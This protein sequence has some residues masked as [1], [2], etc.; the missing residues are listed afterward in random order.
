MNQISV[1]SSQKYKSKFNYKFDEAEHDITD[2]IHCVERYGRQ[3]ALSNS[4]LCYIACSNFKNME[5]A[6]LVLDSI[7][8]EDQ[9]DW[10][11]V[12]SILLSQFGKTRQDWW[13]EFG[14]RKRKST[15]S[16]H[17]LLAALTLLHKKA[18]GKE[19]LSEDNKNEIVRRFKSAVNPI[20]LGHLEA[21]NTVS[22]EKIAADANRLERA[23]NIPRVPT[24]RIQTLTFPT[25]Q[26]P[27]EPVHPEKLDEKLPGKR[28]YNE[29]YSLCGKNTHPLKWCFYNPLS[30]KFKGL[31]WIR[32]QTERAKNA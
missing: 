25:A 13:A 12:K 7:N 24:A 28:P 9:G 32:T 6:T 10:E 2:Y 16:T 20:L 27:E 8:I 29:R 3:F 22:Y 1:N 19:S 21:Q 15:E 26:K 31:D 11:S 4:D 14:R 17:Q 5:M 18:S 23:Y 30:E